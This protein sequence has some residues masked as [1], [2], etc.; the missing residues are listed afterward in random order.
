MDS[1]GDD[2]LRGCNAWY[3]SG[4]HVLRQYSGYGRISHIFYDAADSFSEALLL[5]LV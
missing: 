4:I 5:H 2:F 1:L 3:N